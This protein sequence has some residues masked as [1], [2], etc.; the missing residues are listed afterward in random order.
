M[1]Q[2]MSDQEVAEVMG[3]SPDQVCVIRRSYVDPQQSVMAIGERLRDGL[4]TVLQT[5]FG[6]FCKTSKNQC[7]AGVAQW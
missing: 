5:F 2:G 3:W 4:Q 1:K 6:K 7:L